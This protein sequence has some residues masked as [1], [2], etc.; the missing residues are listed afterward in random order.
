[1]QVRIQESQIFGDPELKDYLV[2]ISV[3]DPNECK[4][5]SKRI[6]TF[7]T[8]QIKIKIKIIC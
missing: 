5:K 1:M 2:V 8:S 7:C 4:S 6:Q 3:V